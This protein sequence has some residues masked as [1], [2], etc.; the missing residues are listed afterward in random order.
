[1][2]RITVE[3]VPH[4]VEKNK[5]KIGEM[6]IALAHVD[7]ANNGDY[8]GWVSHDDWTGTGPLYGKVN[9]HDRHN[10]VWS[11]I[12]KM[13][14]AIGAGADVPDNQPESLASR[15]LGRLKKRKK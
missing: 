12:A 1:M 15:L 3:L 10:S 9:S 11:L 5:R 7:A 4:G 6:V 8:E 13:A 2:L 14:K